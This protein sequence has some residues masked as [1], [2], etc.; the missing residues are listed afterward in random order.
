MAGSVSVSRTQTL[1]D[2]L[3]ARYLEV[4]T[5]TW[6]GDASDGTVPA[7]SIGV[8]RGTLERFVTNPGAGP[9]TSNY[10]ITLTD[11]NGFDVL[12]GAGADRHT[13]TTEEGAVA[14]G[15]YFQRTVAEALTF[16][17]ANQSQA[18]AAGTFTLYVK[19]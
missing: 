2:V 5:V 17:I 4:I 7:T 15:T 6:T 10:D 1:V 12:A 9:P 11:A 14:L 19:R 8:V 18:S 16:T 3:G 13:S